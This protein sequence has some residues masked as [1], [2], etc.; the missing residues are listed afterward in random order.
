MIELLFA[1]MLSWPALLLLLSIGIVAEF[2]GGSGFAVLVG[3]IS[4]IVAYFFFEVTLTALLAFTGVYFVVGFIWSFWRYKRH[5]DAIIEDANT[6]SSARATEYAVERLK[7]SNMVDKIVAWVLIWPFSM[8]EKLTS[9]LVA[10]V[11]EFVS[12]FFKSI[13][14]KIY[15]SAVGKI[16]ESTKQ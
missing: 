5:C 16:N 13:Y 9:D 10:I 11:K 2:N 8:V 14:A 1:W 3:I 6:Q 12:N 4:A 15:Q 7:P